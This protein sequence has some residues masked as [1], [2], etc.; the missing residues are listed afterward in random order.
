MLVLHPPTLIRTLHRHFHH[1]ITIL[2]VHSVYGSSKASLPFTVHRVEQIGLNGVI[3]T[4]VPYYH[5]GLFVKERCVA[6]PL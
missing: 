3:T 5:S 1:V 2:T 4:Y 6:V